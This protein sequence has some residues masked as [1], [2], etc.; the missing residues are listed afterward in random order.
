M[1]NN[2]DSN[3]NNVC[4]PRLGACG[5]SLSLPGRLVLS[6]LVRARNRQMVNVRQGMYGHTLTQGFLSSRQELVTSSCIV[7]VLLVN[8]IKALDKLGFFYVLP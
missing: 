3:D 4:Q 2:D 5:A 7:V 6:D 1:Y 8:V